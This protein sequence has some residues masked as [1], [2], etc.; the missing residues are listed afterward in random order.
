MMMTT[1]QA[2]MAKVG[3]MTGTAKVK[4]TVGRPCRQIRNYA[5]SRPGGVIRWNEA[6]DIYIKNSEA[7]KHDEQ[8]GET[9]YHLNI[10]WI[11]RKYFLKV[12]GVRGFY[13]LKSMADGDNETLEE[14]LGV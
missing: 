2:N 7:A 1:S 12:E 5:S 14:L 13:V 8:N 3:F 10:R 6:R 4:R 11:F 9:H